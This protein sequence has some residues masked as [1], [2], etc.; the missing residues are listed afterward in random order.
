MRGIATDRCETPPSYP[1]SKHIHRSLR[2]GDIRTCVFVYVCM[3][4]CMYV[5]TYTYIHT[6]VRCGA[7]RYVGLLYQRPRSQPC[8]TDGL[9]RPA[10]SWWWGVSGSGGP[11]GAVVSHVSPVSLS[12][13]F[14]LP[15]R[16]DVLYVKFS[17]RTKGVKASSK[18]SRV[19]CSIKCTF[20]DASS[21]FPA[22]YA[23]GPAGAAPR[24]WRIR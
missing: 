17:R 9:M 21:R 1:R 10:T 11:L 13:I 3:Y 18:W 6:A 19:F 2:R 5:H 24:S 15:R 20:A 7:V 8:E 23:H 4:L 12:F 22:G 14:S 16:V